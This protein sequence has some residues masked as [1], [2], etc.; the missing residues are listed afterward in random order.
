[1][2][3]AAVETNQHRPSA[4][5]LESADGRTIARLA[6]EVLMRDRR[7]R[8]M[9]H[10]ITA[11]TA[12]ALALFATSAAV[13]DPPSR[14]VLGPAPAIETTAACG[15]P[16][17]LQEGNET[18]SIVRTWTD[19]DG[20]IRE[21]WTF[22]HGTLNLTNLATGKQ[23]VL[24]GFSGRQLWTYPADGSA[25]LSSTGKTLWGRA[26]PVTGERGFFLF[27]GHVVATFGQ[28]GFVDTFELV[29]GQT[30]ALCPLVS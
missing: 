15:F 11:A 14:E 2:S 24:R 1:M 17:R 13:A 29:G 28:N 18:R 22:S 5:R 27:T 4:R 16:V 3:A 25:T 9:R 10:T 6:V 19:G 21:L 7:S 20:S 23:T 12:L 26:H 8:S 30:T